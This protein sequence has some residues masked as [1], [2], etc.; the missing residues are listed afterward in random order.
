LLNHFLK[1]E[2]RRAYRRK[3]SARSKPPQFKCGPPAVEPPSS[4]LTDY[5]SDFTDNF[6]LTSSKLGGVI[7][8]N[9]SIDSVAATDSNSDYNA[10]SDINSTTSV[11]TLHQFPARKPFKSSI[12]NSRR[13][14]IQEI[15]IPVWP[16][17]Y[18]KAYNLFQ[19]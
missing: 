11:S 4:S 14:V 15:Y 1:Q 9:D 10:A 18:S 2:R 17:H 12:Q 7:D 5:E 16:T 13:I 8:Y 3:R 19:L 6:F